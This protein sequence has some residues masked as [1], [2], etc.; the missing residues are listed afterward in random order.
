M[1]TPPD[2]EPEALSWVHRGWEHLRAQRPLAAW[3]SWQRAL[4][5]K[6]EDPAATQALSIL[7][8]ADDFPPAARSVYRFRSPR[9]DAGRIRWDAAFRGRA[10][11]DLQVAAAVFASLTRAD[12]TDAPAFFNQALCLAW[13]GSNVEAIEALDAAM[14]LDAP[15]LPD[16]AIEAWAL[17]EIL[18]QGGGAETRADELSHTLTIPWTGRDD[19]PIAWLSAFALLREL[20]IPLSLDDEPQPEGQP[21]AFEWLDRPMPESTPTL[22][23]GDLP[24][25][26]A[27]VVVAPTSLSFNSPVDDDLRKVEALLREASPSLLDGSDRRSTPLPI[28]LID[29]AAFRFRLP[30]GLD[31]AAR[32]RLIR[33]ALESYF[34][35]RWI[36]VDRQSLG[37]LCGSKSPSG[38][39]R[40]LDL[41]GGKTADE[42]IA[43]VALEAVIR[44]REQLG[45][46]RN[47]APLYD[48]YPFDRLR[49]RLGLD[50]RE[51]GDVDPADV[52]CMSGRDLA[53][54]DPKAL[55][56]VGLVDAFRSACAI[57]AEAA[58]RL[59]IAIVG[60]DP[61]ATGLASA[62]IAAARRAGA[63]AWIE[64]A[65]ASDGG[66][67]PL[68]FQQLREGL[69]ERSAI[70]GD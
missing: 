64:R 43:R 17:A 54:L 44:V 25:V 34:E 36:A 46:R 9:D 53:K 2:H 22:T 4:L 41:G 37:D 40:S 65:I 45:R 59:A 12:P 35:D 52:S 5:L 1:S 28:R 13:A 6:P 18:R 10:T 56:D 11:G 55:D 42:A 69:P 33:E 3:G 32:R 51:P 39:P 24:T 26:L 50:P 30:E 38:S 23:A 27:G 49:R 66:P 68:F 48:G 21:R 16:A 67:H 58:A 19:D 63:R 7:A 61:S 15:S 62:V 70:G 47:F 14:R 57:H 60:R 8:A 31:E 29:A 20:V